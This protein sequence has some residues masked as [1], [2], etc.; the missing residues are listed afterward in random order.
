MA[1]VALEPPSSSLDM[2]ASAR[3]V[4]A[5][6]P[7]NGEARTPPTEIQSLKSVNRVLGLFNWEQ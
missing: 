4:F 5:R 7:W 6:I 3:L 2:L 1:E